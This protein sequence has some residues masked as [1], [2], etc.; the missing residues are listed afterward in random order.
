MRAARSSIEVTVNR[1]TSRQPA[2]ARETEKWYTSQVPRQTP[3]NVY[4]KKYSEERTGGERCPAE[5]RGGT[6]QRHEE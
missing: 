2:Y 5:P 1:T 6:F 3:E 4:A